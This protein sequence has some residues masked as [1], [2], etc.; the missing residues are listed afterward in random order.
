MAR[1][2]FV[3]NQWPHLLNRAKSIIQPLMYYRGEQF[4]RR[5]MAGVTVIFQ[6]R[7]EILVFLRRRFA[8]NNLIV[9]A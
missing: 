2:L 9:D 5:R 1:S 8:D 3:N 4:N 6:K 7:K